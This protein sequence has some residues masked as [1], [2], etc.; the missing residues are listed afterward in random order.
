MIP[1]IP[2]IVSVIILYFLKF[3]TKYNPHIWWI[4][5]GFHQIGSGLFVLLMAGA[6]F[7]IAGN[8]YWYWLG[9]Y[10]AYVGIPAGT[11]LLIAGCIVIIRGLKRYKSEKMSKEKEN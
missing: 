1:F 9:S 8:T 6:S 10:Y 3:Y 5:N 4:K 11:I 2:L 7:A